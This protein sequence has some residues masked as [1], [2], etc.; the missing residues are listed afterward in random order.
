MASTREL[1]LDLRHSH[2]IEV[3]ASD[4]GH[5][6]QERPKTEAECALYCKA[7]D[8]K[9]GQASSESDIRLLIDLNVKIHFDA[10]VFVTDFG[11]TQPSEFRRGG[12]EIEASGLQGLQ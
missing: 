12:A 10:C 6:R 9:A 2:E 5:Y 3:H 11:Y 4:D 8:A 7:S 1:K